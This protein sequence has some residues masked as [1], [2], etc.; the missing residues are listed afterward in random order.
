ML[1]ARLWRYLRPL[2]F[3]GGGAATGTVAAVVLASVMRPLLACTVDWM[4]KLS[5][6]IVKFLEVVGIDSAR[7]IEF[8]GQN[9]EWSAVDLG[10]GALGGSV[11]LATIRDTLGELRKMVLNWSSVSTEILLSA[12][13]TVFVTF[14][15]LTLSV[16]GLMNAIPPAT[17]T[18]KD[19]SV[20]P[21]RTPILLIDSPGVFALLP[22]LF[23]S[24]GTK[25]EYWSDAYLREVGPDP[26]LETEYVWHAKDS[27][28]A[29]DG[30]TLTDSMKA[31]LN[32]FLGAIRTCAREASTA[33]P[34]VLTVEGFASSRDFC[35]E[36]KDLLRTVSVEALDSLEA[37]A[38]NEAEL[39]HSQ[40]DWLNVMTA[41][42]RASVVYEHLKSNVDS[43]VFEISA[44][45]PHSDF[46]SMVNLRRY[47]DEIRGLRREDAEAVTRRV[48]IRVARAPGCA[49]VADI[50]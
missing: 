16:Y 24:A 44:P 3:V 21:E 36:R 12:S 49:G 46:R 17:S 41:N 2:A 15:A 10:Y 47:V 38:G 30:V 39:K 9:H 22:V 33:R 42:K 37:C 6:V 31:D 43:S 45:L 7:P 40:S 26:I 14:L 27:R 8:G 1:R 25:D 32:E 48:D 50:G 34:I 35:R 23:E 11:L 5:N 13:W 4:Q 20:Q 29:T 19:S 28:K 18:P